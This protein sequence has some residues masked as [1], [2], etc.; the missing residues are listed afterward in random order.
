MGYL[1]E[2]LLEEYD[3]DNLQKLLKMQQLS[4]QHIPNEKMWL[5]Y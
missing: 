2:K 5:R 4:V 1:I 3:E